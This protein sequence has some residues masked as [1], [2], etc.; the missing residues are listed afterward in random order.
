VIVQEAASI[1]A[2]RVAAETGA[3]T[4]IVVLIDAEGNGGIGAATPAGTADPRAHALS[5]LGQII[6]REKSGAT[7]SAVPS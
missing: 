4:V 7:S 2:Q 5:I 3:T 6:A 1:E